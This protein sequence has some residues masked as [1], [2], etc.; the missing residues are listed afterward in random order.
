MPHLG[1]EIMIIFVMG[2]GGIVAVAVVAVVTAGALGDVVAS[3]LQAY[4][5]I[6]E[7]PQSSSW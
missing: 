4:F 3:F 7:D 1:H 5:A 6:K 2:G